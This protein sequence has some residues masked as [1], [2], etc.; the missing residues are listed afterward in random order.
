MPNPILH[1]LHLTCIVCWFATPEGGE[2]RGGVDAAD[3]SARGTTP[4]DAFYT[5]EASWLRRAR[6]PH[7]E[8]RD[9][10]WQ[11][12]VLVARLSYPTDSVCLYIYVL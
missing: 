6:A 11:E 5:E 2:G 12:G 3:P 7:Q 10:A 8:G 4:T 9:E 1:C